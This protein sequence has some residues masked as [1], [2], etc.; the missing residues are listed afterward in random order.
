VSLR[1]P[2][3]AIPVATTGTSLEVLPSG[4]AVLIR[5][6]SQ[7]RGVAAW[8]ARALRFQSRRRYQLD[9]LGVCFWSQI[10]GQRRLS[11]IQGTLCLRYSLS[12]EQARRAI[13]QFTAALMRRNL[14]AL[15][16]DE[17]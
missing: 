17:S 10:D 6:E 11:D 7:T 12:P 13:V 2:L 3:S 9:D 15:R 1:D 14:L 4:G 8:L 16:V 5:R